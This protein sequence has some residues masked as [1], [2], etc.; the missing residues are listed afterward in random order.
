[1]IRRPPR[2]TRTDTLV[3]ST[4]LFR[5]G[6]RTGSSTPDV[7]SIV[8][9]IAVA[10]VIGRAG[11]ERHAG[12]EH[13]SDHSCLTHDPNSLGEKTG[14]RIMLATNAEAR[15]CPDA[16]R[17]RE[18]PHFVPAIVPCLRPAQ[19][20][21]NAPIRHESPRLSGDE[22]K[23]THGNGMKAVRKGQD[24]AR[25]DDDFGCDEG[26]VRHLPPSAQSRGLCGN[27]PGCRP[28]NGA[29]RAR[30]RLRRTPPSRTRQGSHADRAFDLNR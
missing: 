12:G 26:A 16:R 22:A 6:G 13:N 29:L 28:G 19:P 11:T 18:P 23:A 25:S 17:Q 10:A 15:A 20:V 3:P 9:T 1:M 8:V 24:E 7:A 4:T 14:R 27:H 30:A 21:E 2:S 5:S